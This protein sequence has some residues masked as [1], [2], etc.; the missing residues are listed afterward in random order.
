MRDYQLEGLE[1]LRLLHQNN[2]NGILADEM[3]LGKT[4]QCIALIAHLIETN[5][6]D[7][8]LG[9]YLVI[10]PLSTLH[11]WKSEFERFA[12]LIPTLLFHGNKKKRIKLRKE[13]NNLVDIYSFGKSKV[14]FPVVI[15][16]YEMFKS[17]IGIMKKYNWNYVI[18][19]EGHKIKNINCQLSKLLYLYTYYTY[20]IILLL[21][22][23]TF[24][25][26]KSY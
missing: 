26:F 18:I 13:F 11:N 14:C 16:S 3:G 1:W 6:T 7:E 5:E 10:A 21:I 24:L 15:T 12:P 17:E 25:V 2:M 20:I 22:I 23:F 8:Y 4:I 19:D 9:P